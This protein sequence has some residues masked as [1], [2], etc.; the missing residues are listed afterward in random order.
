[1]ADALRVALAGLGTVGGGVVKLLDA[2]RELITRRAGR[3]IEVVAV[4]ARDRTKDRGID[5][6][7]FQ[8]IDDTSALAQQADVDVVVELIG[9]SDGPALTLARATLAKG[10]HIVTANKAMLAHH[11][12]ELAQAAEAAGAALKFEAAVAGGIPVIKGLREGA[13]ANEIGRVYGILN[14]TCNFI[15]SKMEAEGRDFAE[16]L[17]EAQALGF[18]EADPTFDI[19]GIDAAHKLSILASLAFGTQPAFEHVA[20]TGIR[21]VLGADIAEAAALGYRVRLVGLAEAGKAGLF[22]RVHPHLVPIDHPLAHVTGSTNAVVA[23][24]NF[25]GRLLLQGAGA[26]EGPTASAVVADLIDIARGEYGPPFAMPAAS[27][28]AA[29][30]A[31]AGERRGRAYLRFLVEDRVGVLAE[32]AAAMRDAGVSIESLIQRGATADGH[33]LVAIVTHEGPERSVAQ[34]LERL[35][36]SPSVAGS[37]LWMHILG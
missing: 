37:P 3:P 22:Q 16:V 33:V 20:A 30:V 13:A 7:R 27:L 36:G 23:E 14:G 1:M 29:E 4:S 6:S 25:V 21:H 9:G 12:L 11:G 15:L 32:I 24:G 17:A 26:G 19:D 10:R 28:V 5:L 31:D 2:N 35:R 8:W 34:A 18:A